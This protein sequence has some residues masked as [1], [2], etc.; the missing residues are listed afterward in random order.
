M[1]EQEEEYHGKKIHVDDETLDVEI[2]GEHLNAFRDGDGNYRLEEYGYDPK[3]S[4][5]EVAERYVD[6]HEGDEDDN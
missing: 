6:Y 2:D 5:L 3:E 4:L 1:V